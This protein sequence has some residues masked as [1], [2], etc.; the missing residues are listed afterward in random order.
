MINEIHKMQ[1]SWVVSDEQLQSELRV[2]ITAVVVPAYRSFLGWFLQ[3]LDP[4]QQTEKYIKFG[5]H[6]LQNCIDELFDGNRFS[7]MARR[8]T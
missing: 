3:Y 6:D 8:R 1:S 4:G 5:A 7:S 2:S